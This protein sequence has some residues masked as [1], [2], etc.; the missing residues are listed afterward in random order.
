MAA[1][2]CASVSQSGA[3]HASARV[4]ET[5]SRTVRTQHPPVCIV[6][7]SASSSLPLGDPRRRPSM[8]WHRPSAIAD[9]AVRSLR[10][11][12]GR[13]VSGGAGAGPVTE[14]CPLFAAATPLSAAPMHA[15]T[16]THTHAHLCSSASAS[17]TSGSGPAWRLSAAPCLLAPLDIQCPCHAFSNFG[18]SGCR[19]QIEAAESRGITGMG[20]GTEYQ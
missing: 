17:S 11:R 3:A 10:T 18:C 19:E 9:A 12:T 15:S 20:E 14:R 16:R 13:R 5:T 7:R 2:D 8:L 6:C 4:S 1:P